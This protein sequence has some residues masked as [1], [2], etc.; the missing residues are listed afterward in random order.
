MRHC[1][2]VSFEISDG[3]RRILAIAIDPMAMIVLAT[4]PTRGGICRTDRSA[5][6]RAAI[7]SSL[8]QSTSPGVP[9]CALRRSRRA[10]NRAHDHLHN[11]ADVDERLCPELDLF[12]RW[13]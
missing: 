4:L 12:L 9:G 1:A 3:T 8:A 7:S 5:N 13:A 10:G 6:V 11:A 2:K